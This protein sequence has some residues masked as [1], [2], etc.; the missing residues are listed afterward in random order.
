MWEQYLIYFMLGVFPWIFV[1]AGVWLMI[2]AHRFMKDARR[3]TGR[4]VAVHQSTSYRSSNS[5]G[6]RRVTTY[7]PVFAYTAPDGSAHEARTAIYSTSYNFP[8]GSEHEILCNPATPDTVRMPG[9][10][11]YGFGGL[12]AAIGLVF[13]IV[14]IFAMQA[15]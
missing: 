14:G 11:V 15:M 8:V 4:V 6:G 13:G 1:A 5:G 7:Q 2:R 3:A 10:W 12:F 9:F